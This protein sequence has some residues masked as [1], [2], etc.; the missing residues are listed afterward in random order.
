MDGA[1]VKLDRAETNASGEAHDRV[2]M[3]ASQAL[4]RANRTALSEGADDGDLPIERKNVH[5]AR[6]LE[7]GRSARATLVRAAKNRYIAVQRSLLRGAIPGV[8]IA[9]AGPLA[10]GLD[11]A[12]CELLVPGQGSDL[13]SLACKAGVLPIRRTGK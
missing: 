13:D 5:G 3:D 6:S 2:A 11:P 12:N 8:V 4:D 1:I 7:F 10:G 9:G